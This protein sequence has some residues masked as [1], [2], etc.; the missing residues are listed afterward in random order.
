MARGLFTLKQQLQ[1]L[2][3]KA[4]NAPF[5]NTYAAVF[6]GSNYITGPSS[7]ALNFGTGNFTIECWIYPTA[8][9]FGGIIS[10]ILTTAAGLQIAL[11]LPSNNGLYWYTSAGMG[12][13][14]TNSALIPPVGRWTHLVLV[15]SGSTVSFYNNGVRIGTTTNSGSHSISSPYIGINSDGANYGFIGQ[16]SNFRVTNTAVYDPTV[17]WLTVPTSP[18]TAISGTQL[19]TFQNATITD[20]STNSL[21]LTNN[22]SVTTQLANPFGIQFPTPAVDYLVVAGGGGGGYYRSGGGGGGGLLQGSVSIIAGSA[23]TVTVGAGGA[24]NTG[25]GAGQG[26]SGSSS[27]FGSISAGGGGGGGGNGAGGSVGL[28]GGSGGGG[29]YGTTYSTP[30]QGI[31]GQGNSGGYGNT[32][33]SNG[34]GGGGGAGT[35]GL[36]W[37]NTTGGNGGAG[38]ASAIS[39]TVTAYAGGGGGGNANQGSSPYNSAGGV[40]GGGVGG[41]N[42]GSGTAGTVNTGGGGGGGTGEGGTQRGWD[43]GSGIVIVSYPDIYAAAAATTGSPTV[44]TN[45]SG[46][47]YGAGAGSL[48]YTGVNTTLTF[49]GDFTIEGWYNLANFNNAAGGGNP[50]LIGFGTSN[51]VLVIPGGQYYFYSG[52]SAILSS[53]SAVANANVWNHFALVRSGSS[54]VIYHNGVSVGTATNSSTISIGSSG[55]TVG[56]NGLSGTGSITGYMSNVR[57]VKGTAVYTSA[58]T[59]PTTPLT[60]ITNTQLLLNTVS[61][62][63]YLDS[64]TNGYTPTVASP[65]LW[66]QLSPFATGLGYKNR[67]YTWTSS[68]SITF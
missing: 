31:I 58:F 56:S 12:L 23:I 33:S 43:G 27:V 62:N 45:G 39:G 35:A 63:Q 30:G 6:S 7:S 17:A 24:S 13:Q 40:G 29:T 54:M 49:A 34:G 16:I 26:S 22:G 66:N 65:L 38:I 21:S 42:T 4:W 44:S 51:W 8:L 67:V 25:S 64:S 59:P 20:S 47:M 5:G 36:N 32:A 11:S 10:M 15:R 41:G 52:G 50:G 61:P 60:A 1:G 55:V 9:N 37:N 28:N 46:S 19:L 14:V 57:V 2:Q 18:L 53:S 48:L 3:Q 68:G